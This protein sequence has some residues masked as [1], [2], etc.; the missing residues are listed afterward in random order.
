MLEEMMDISNMYYFDV[1]YLSL[2][3]E[4]WKYIHEKLHNIIIVNFAYYTGGSNDN[5]HR[6]VIMDLDWVQYFL[7][8]NEVKFKM[9]LVVFLCICAWTVQCNWNSITGRPFWLTKVFS[10]S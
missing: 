4:H 5:I 6:V 8:I 10:F 9:L 7:Y 3:V 2:N 1:M